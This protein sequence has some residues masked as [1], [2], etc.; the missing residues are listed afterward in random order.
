LFGLIFVIIIVQVPYNSTLS[1]KGLLMELNAKE[2]YEVLRE[3]G[4]ENLYHANTVRTSCTFLSHSR[5]MGRGIGEERSLPQTSQPSDEKDKRYGLWYD[6]FLD[7]VAV[8]R[9][10]GQRNYYSP[11]LFVLDLG[12]LQCDWLASMW[13]TKSN[14]G[15]WTDDTPLEQRYFSDIEE[16]RNGYELGTFKQS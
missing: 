13:V 7:S 8:H 10:S 5:L 2:V 4:V 11:V 12:L 16:V 6:I 9:R 1:K 14:P 15:K 3:K